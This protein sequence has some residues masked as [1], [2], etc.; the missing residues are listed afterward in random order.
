MNKASCD[1]ST[2]SGCTAL[3][4]F[5]HRPQAT[6]PPVPQVCSKDLL[7]AIEEYLANDGSHGIFDAIKLAEARTKL[8]GLVDQDKIRKLQHRPF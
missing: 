5:E 4:C 1:I 8:N 3:E 2:A 7:N 6:N